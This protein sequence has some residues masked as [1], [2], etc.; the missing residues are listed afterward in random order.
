MAKTVRRYAVAYGLSMQQA[1]QTAIRQMLHN[2]R[3][4]LIQHIVGEDAELLRRLAR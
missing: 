4:R 3:A 2:K 1:A